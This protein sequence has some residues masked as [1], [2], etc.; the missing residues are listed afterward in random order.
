MNKA[1]TVF[2]SVTKIAAY[3]PIVLLFSLIAVLLWNAMPSIIHS[4]W[5]FFLTAAWNPVTNEFGALSA[6]VGTLLTSLI[7]I[8]FAVP[9][10]FGI[11]IFAIY[12]LTGTKAEIL[13]R[14]IELMAAIPSIIY[15][16]WGLFILV[17]FLSQY[18]QPPVINLFSNV[19]LLNHVFSGLPIGIGVFTAGIILALMI[20]PLITAMMLNIIKSVPALLIETGYAVG[21][22]TY[23]IVVKIILHYARAG[24]FGSV[25]LGLGRALGETMAVT[26]VIGNMHSLPHGLFYPA[27]T[28]SASIASE[29]TEATGTL[30]QAALLELSL[31]LFFITTITL[32]IA[33]LLL[34]KS[35]LRGGSQ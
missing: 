32:L 15:G 20:I 33:R 19:P 21:A 17:P 13:S 10:S 16:M 30:Y 29:F 7:A 14:F 27:T 8:I 24:L 6:I 26:F 5:H 23:E 35:K 3:L 34:E 31:L 25:I 1:D 28:I 2:Y 22:S 9:I 12:H 18:V 4:K 11:S